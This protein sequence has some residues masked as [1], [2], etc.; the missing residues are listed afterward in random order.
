MPLQVRIPR[1]QTEPSFVEEQDVLS[2]A[3]FNAPVSPFCVAGL[4]CHPG[5]I[6]GCCLLSSRWWFV[7]GFGVL[8]LVLV[9]FVFGVQPVQ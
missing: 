2:A 7:V 6:T 4:Q 9:W 3:E 5:Y 1:H 8:C